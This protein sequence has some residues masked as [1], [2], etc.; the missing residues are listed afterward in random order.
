LTAAGYPYCSTHCHSTT[1][2][3]A[4]GCAA[5]CSA[6]ANAVWDRVAAVL[7]A[8]DLHGCMC[9]FVCMCTC[10]CVVYVHVCVCACVRACMQ[11]CA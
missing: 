11:V 1:Q 3:R 4:G 9:M 5:R 10:V 8:S 6:A 7:L 2:G